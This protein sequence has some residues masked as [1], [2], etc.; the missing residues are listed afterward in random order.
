MPECAPSLISVCGLSKTFGRRRV[1][2]DID[3]E[4]KKGEFL[5]IFGPNG[6]G[7]TTLIKILATLI[8]SSSGTVCLDGIELK[9]DPLTA[10]ERIGLISHE[11]LLYGDLTAHENLRFYGRMFGVSNLEE[12]ISH[13]LEKVE[14]EHRKFDLVRT[15]SRGMQQRLSIARALLHEPSILLLD[16]P[17]S[18]L[19]PHATEILDGIL[20]DLRKDDHTFIMATHNLEKGL[21]HATSVLI[22]S[23]GRIVF[24]GRKDALDIS[25]FRKTYD[26]YVGG[27]V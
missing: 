2:E 3:F 26:S 13:L 16:E 11:S 12:R 15:F 25:D 14:L 21:N 6:A 20:E 19:D 9:K 23:Q 18:G 7:K 27:H 1:L 10:R 4:V 5:A 8:L 24:G 17:H 22:L